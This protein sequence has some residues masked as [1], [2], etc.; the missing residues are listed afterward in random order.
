MSPL[1]SPMSS[2]FVGFIG[3]IAGVL[4]AGG[5][6][7]LLTAR[8]RRRD[9]RVAAALIFADLAT[10]RGLLDMVVSGD[11]SEP[12][13]EE[14]HRFLD[15]WREQRLPLAGGVS[16][17]E[18]HTIAG[19]FKLLENAAAGSRVGPPLSDK[20]GVLTALQVFDRASRV[21]WHAS[22]MKSDA[23][24]TS[25][26]QAASQSSAP[27]TNVEPEAPESRS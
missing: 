23:D 17:T 20:L 8:D 3:V 11:A 4:A 24:G 9:A 12:P 13:P 10:A 19:A 2:A 18:F 7:A 5:M 25:T 1:V 14:L 27:G 15:V 21:A 16:P 26:A 6:Q 22:G